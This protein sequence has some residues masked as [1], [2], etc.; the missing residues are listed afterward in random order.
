MQHDAD[1]VFGREVS[2]LLKA[3]PQ[4]CAI[5]VEGECHLADIENKSLGH[6]Q[7]LTPFNISRSGHRNM[8]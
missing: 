8:R 7:M 5:S 4:I 3:Q 1:L 2:I 6:L